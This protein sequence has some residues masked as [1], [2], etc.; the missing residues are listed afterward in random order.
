MSNKYLEKIAK[1]KEL[2]SE[3]KKAL[4]GAAT[5]GGASVIHNEYHRGNITGRET[6]FHG[7]APVYKEEIL[8]EGIK[9]RAKKGI[10]DVAEG[11]HGQSLNSDNLSFMTR[12]R[13]Q[14]HTYANQAERIRKGT[15]NIN[16]LADR[17]KDMVPGKTSM[18]GVVKVNAPTWKKDEFHKVRNPELK[19]MFKAVNKGPE[20]M[21]HT[22][23]QRKTVKSGIYDKLEKRVFTN[24]GTVSNKYIKGSNAYAKNSLKEIG[25]FIKHN[26][27]R[28]AKGVG[29]SALGAA[30]VSGG[31]KLFHSGNKGSGNGK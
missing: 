8:R 23:A 29:K 21:F 24:K 10:I 3:Q 6:L 26:P 2:S 7:T 19:T 14:A 30:L 27:G 12:S 25:E 20:F 15:F 31:V 28:F 9:P 11:A 18:K 17:L 4:G 5:L 1:S 16:D 13:H 22:K